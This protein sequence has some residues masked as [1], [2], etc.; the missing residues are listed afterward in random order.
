MHKI[1]N[2]EALYAAIRAAKHCVV[3]T[4]AGIST[5]SGIPDF[6]G[7]DGLYKRVEIDPERLFQIEA[8]VRDPS[9]Y[10]SWA[11][12]Y[13]YTYKEVTP[14]IVHHVLAKLER[15][16]HI[17]AVITQNIDL[18]HQK[19][20]S[21]KVLEVHGS[22]ALHYCLSCNKEYSFDEIMDM[23]E[24]SQTPSCKKCQG[25]IKPRI[26]FFGEALPRDVLQNAF[27]HAQKADLMLVL[28]SSLTVYP[29]ASIPE[30]TLQQGGQLV[31]VNA[32]PTAL[33]R[34]AEGTF[35][36]LAS[37]FTELAGMVQLPSK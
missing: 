25:I 17:K 32:D 8:F 31:L 13:I 9:Y 14:N 20:G 30:I 36:D 10:Y 29:A 18:L 15:Q 7:K 22:P 33:D 16:N 26:V 28:G 21:S 12:D 19:A 1:S 5:L 27:D 23:L 2:A 4:G 3:L 34:Y 11:R 24:A 35:T 6:R 37:L